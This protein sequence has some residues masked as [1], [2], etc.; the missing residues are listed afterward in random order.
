SNKQPFPI[1]DEATI[2]IKKLRYKTKD[3]WR[4]EDQQIEIGELKLAS[5]KIDL[6]KKSI[7]LEN[8]SIENQRFYIRQYKGN[9]PD[10]LRPKPEPRVAGQLYWNPDQWTI[11]AKSI[12]IK[13]GFFSSDLDTQRDPYPYFD[14]A[15]LAFDQI[16]GE[17]KNFMLVKDTVKAEINLATK[18][19]S[20]FEVNSL[21]AFMHMDPDKMSFDQLK[22]T[23][24]YSVLGDYFSMEYQYF[25]EDMAKFISNVRMKGLI[26]KSKIDL[27]DI[28]FFAPQLKNLKYTFDVDAEVNGPVENLT[29]EKM[30]V[31]FGSNT[32]LDGSLTINGLPDVANTTYEL[33]NSLLVSNA[34]DLYTLIPVLKKNLGIDLNTLVNFNFRGNAFATASDLKIEGSIGTALGSVSTIAN[35]KNLT[36]TSIEYGLEGKINSFEFGK[37][38]T[39]SGLGKTSGRYNVNGK[40]KGVINFNAK[41]DSLYFNEYRYTNLNARGGLSKKILESTFEVDDENLL[42]SLMAKIDYNDS[43]PRSLIDAQVHLADLQQMKVTKLPLQFSGKTKIDITG[44]NP[45][46]INGTAKLN[47]FTVFRDGKPYVFDS[48]LFSSQRDSSYRMLTLLGKDIDGRLE[49]D[50]DFA[51]LPAT[52]NQ[53]FSNYYPLY[54]TKKDPPKREQNLEFSLELKNASPFLKILDNG[55]GGLDYSKIEGSIDTRNRIF[56]LDANIPRF[57]YNKISIDDFLLNAYGDTDSLKVFSKASSFVIN[58]SLFFPNNEIQIQSSK[59]LSYVNINTTSTYSDYGAK[60]S[61][62][63]RNIEDGI[64]IH[65][66][67]SSLVFNEKTWNIDED[68]ELLISKKRFDAENILLKNGDQRISLVT[69]P[70]EANQAQ[71]IIL[72]LT[73]VN[74]GELLPFF[75]KEPKIQ[76]ITTGDLTVED[77]FNNLRLYLNAQTDQTRFEDD[78][79]G[80]TSINA[81]WDD[82]QKRSSFFLESDNPYYQFDINGALNLKDSTQEMIETNFN[83]VDVNLSILEPYLGVVFSKIQGKGTGMLKIIGNV[84]KPDLIGK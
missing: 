42:A 63:V 64:V 4:G 21:T 57:T 54:F 79:I 16:N 71:T 19:R 49:G 50:F 8:I 46:N 68:G 69:L 39:L 59:N 26:S 67:P 23:T 51:E 38:L 3:A 60:L 7:D 2:V 66:N 28:A 37:L 56:R 33:K 82:K 44:N 13:N 53:Y 34:N 36:S 25:S 76:G 78:S 30:R 77:P 24:P 75:L 35:L 31:Y 62:S 29:A 48:L 18:E 22:I 83:L 14:G 80:L 11:L 52:L 20:G 15:H 5:K 45:D 65:F 55:M 12:R 41:L 43:L 17:I 1:I 9:R 61:A 10:S 47:D 73:K 58:D 27:R 74:L 6:I 32:V 72:S 84:R 40:G 70:A 81:F